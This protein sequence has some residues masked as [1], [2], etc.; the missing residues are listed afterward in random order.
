M[1]NKYALITYKNNGKRD[2]IIKN[3]TSSQVEKLYHELFKRERFSL[4]PI[5][6]KLEYDGWHWITINNG[7]EKDICNKGFEFI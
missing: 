6:I 5:I 4:N 2:S 1:K 3:L 7:K